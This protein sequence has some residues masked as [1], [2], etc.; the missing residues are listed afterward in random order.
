MGIGR[1]HHI[2][3]LGDI[4]RLQLLTDALCPGGMAMDENGYIGTE[5]EADI[6]QLG[7]A[8]AGLPEYVEAKQGG[9]R[10]G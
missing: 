10:I 4:R 8:Q 7:N 1:E 3:W 6:G 9:G 2:P 5:F